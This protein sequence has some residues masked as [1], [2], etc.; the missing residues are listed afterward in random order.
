MSRQ[1]KDLQTLWWDWLSTSERLL[2]SLYEQTAALT[3]RNAD[4][5]M[6]LQPEIDGLMK[7]M[8]EVDD[9]AAAIAT[10][11]AESLG[12]EPSLRSLVT[13]LDEAEAQQVQA[14]ANRVI[15]AGQNVQQVM[16]KNRK[17]IDNE[18]EYLGGTLALIA[19]SSDKAQKGYGD[20]AAEGASLTL[21]QVA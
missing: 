1:T 6:Q 18:L 3:M 10:E 5:L 12:V 8:A 11:L 19:R 2:H 16:R 4:R 7:R 13:A 17:L 20:K 21:N 9:R 14:L 15:I